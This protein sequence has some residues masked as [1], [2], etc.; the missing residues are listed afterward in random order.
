MGK[1]YIKTADKTI[2]SIKVQNIGCTNKREQ[3]IPYQVMNVVC[4]S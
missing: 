3:D 4:I 1:N 2:D